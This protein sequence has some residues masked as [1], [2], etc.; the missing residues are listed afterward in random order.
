MTRKKG[1]EFRMLA[2]LVEHVTFYHRVAG[3]NPAA[4]RVHY[5]KTVSEMSVRDITR[6]H[7]TA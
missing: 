7:A 3:S 6:H 4:P 2:Q 1:Q 5:L